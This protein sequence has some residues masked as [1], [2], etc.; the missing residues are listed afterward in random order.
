[1]AR[2]GKN[3][4]K[5]SAKPRQYNKKT[6]VEIFCK[7]CHLCNS[8]KNPSFCYVEL[9]R[10]APK[11][12]VNS[13]WKNLSDV[14]RVYKT[15]SRPATSMSIEQ[16]QNIFCVTGICDNGNMTSCMACD[17]LNLCY[18]M[19]RMQ[20]GALPLNGAKITENS[21]TVIPPAVKGKQKRYTAYQRKKRRRV[22]YTAYPTF[23]SSQDETFKDWIRKTLDGD[24]NN[25]QD[26]G[27]EPAR[28]ASVSTSGDVEDRES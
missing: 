27:E 1:M 19:F 20:L 2:K 18:D 21:G 4:K 13:V 6:F 28:E 25:E 5:K 14:G 26:T 9:Y 3:K 12:F 23:F 8:K 17:K 22:V 24:S 16:F 10:H 7:S 15:K 11:E